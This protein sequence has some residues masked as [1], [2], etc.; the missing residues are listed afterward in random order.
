LSGAN[1]ID[2]DASNAPTN[3]QL[4]R[5]ISCVMKSRIGETPSSSDVPPNRRRVYRNDD[6]D[7]VRM[8]MRHGIASAWAIVIWAAAAGAGCGNQVHLGRIGDDG[9]G[10]GTGGTGGG[11]GVLWRATFEPGDLSEWSGDGYGGPYVENATGSPVAS[12]ERVHN[13]RYA[14]RTSV[15]PTM[16]MLSFNYLYRN[17]PTP[18]EVYYSAWH[19]IP[20]G[21]TL[22]YEPGRTGWLS[23]VHF[24][25]SPTGDGRNP[26]ATWDLNVNQK[27][28]GLLYAHL[29]NYRTQTNVERKTT[30]P[31]L[32]TPFDRWVHIEILMRMATGPWGRLGVW[33]EGYLLLE[34]EGVATV[35]NDWVEW[36]IGSASNDVSPTPA[37]LYVDDAAISLLPVGPGT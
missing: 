17:G 1:S 30:L 28:D 3:T 20:S 34:L 4:L 6:G 29:W 2:E 10:G 35:A 14:G 19:Y 12:T 15:A 26:Y 27:G 5:G 24:R 11:T 21:I 25:G 22:P 9:G 23:L 8:K 33:Q 18:T 31:P 13:G 36:S 32:P 7:Q 16:G 37:L